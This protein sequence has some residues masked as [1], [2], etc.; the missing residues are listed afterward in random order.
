[1]GSRVKSRSSLCAVVAQAESRRAG[2]TM[3]YVGSRG[4]IKLWDNA[5]SGIHS[6]ARS[7]RSKTGKLKVFNRHKGKILLE[8]INIAVLFS[9][10]I[11]IA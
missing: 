1:M 8:D 4:C 5:S 2:A 3:A 6:T 9:A 7:F 10:H 11:C